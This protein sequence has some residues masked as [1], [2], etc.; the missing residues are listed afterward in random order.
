MMVM[1]LMVTMMKVIIRRRKHDNKVPCIHFFWPV[2][3]L[4]WSPY[5]VFD[6]LQVYDLLPADTSNAATA[7]TINAVATFIQSLSALNSAA[8]PLIYCLFSTQLWR[9]FRYLQHDKNSHDNHTLG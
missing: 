5:I 3:I 9:K 1:M 2:F 7:D 8:N 4:C 6:I